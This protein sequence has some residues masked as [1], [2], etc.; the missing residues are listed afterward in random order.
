[1][2][3]AAASTIVAVAAVVM[4]AG[5]SPSV[6]TTEREV[7]PEASDPAVVTTER[8]EPEPSPSPSPDIEGGDA[9][10]EF[11]RA[12][13]SQH[14]SDM[15]AMID[16]SAPNSP[17]RTYA[18]VQIAAAQAMRASQGTT[19][20]A[21]TLEIVDGGIELCDEPIGK[22]GDTL[23]PC[24]R[25]DGFELTDGKLASFAGR[26]LD[27]S[28]EPTEPISVDNRLA[29][30]GQSKEIRG[31]TITLIGA[32]HSIQSDVLAVAFDVEAGD[33]PIE[34][35]YGDEY[36]EADGA[37]VASLQ[38]MGMDAP[39]RNQSGP[40]VVMFDRAKVGGSVI[41]SGQDSDFNSFEMRFEL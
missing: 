41:L 8:A 2:P 24:Y 16:L 29:D 31:N 28:G 22:L 6:E 10:V 17:A 9:V 3:T 30:G 20:P 38:Y 25:V 35:G 37:I 12:F 1:M 39:R 21:Q 4:L 23:N 5:C 36:E 11:F 26:V 7:E 34:L 13:A 32:Y 19:N 14:P 27:D 40:Y 33:N 18:E 15:Q